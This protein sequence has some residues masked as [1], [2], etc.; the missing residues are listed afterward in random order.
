MT[1]TFR[2]IAILFVTIETFSIIQGYVPF[3]EWIP[4]S[5]MCG[6]SFLMY[7]KAFLNK[8]TLLLFIYFSILLLFAAM[9]HTLANIRWV[10]IEI[11]V[12]M[13]CL[14]IINVFIYNRDLYGL[15]L[16]TAVG[17]LIIALTAVL[18][19]PIVIK[20]PS[21]VR[22]MVTY[23][24]DNNVSAA[25]M[26]LRQGIASFGLVHAFPSLCPLLI[27]QIKNGSNN[28][29]RAYFLTVIVAT[30]FMIARASFGT[31]LILSSFA[32]VY[33]FFFTKNIK[34]NI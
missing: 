11:M 10:L 31:P 1:L 27:F 26:Y 23:S 15:K 29:S 4:M 33:A 17:L 2:F 5:M 21:A 8:P 24:I 6:V 30:Y 22:R 32:I 34:I 3:K 13:S 28:L 16:V 25:R 14:S 19:I 12:P 7:P 20:D 9:G 18:T